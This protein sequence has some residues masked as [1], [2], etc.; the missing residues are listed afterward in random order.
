MTTSN[1]KKIEQLRD[2]YYNLMKLGLDIQKKGDIKA[3]MINAIHAE[4][5]AQKMQA[6][7]RGRR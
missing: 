2:E 4:N 7:S 3:Y 6:I 1:D 5:I